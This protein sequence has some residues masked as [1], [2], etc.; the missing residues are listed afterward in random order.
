MF[1]RVARWREYNVRVGPVDPCQ[2]RSIRVTV[3]PE[4]STHLGDCAILALL[5]RSGAGTNLFRS[6]RA[7]RAARIS[8]DV[9]AGLIGDRYC[10]TVAL[11][12]IDGSFIA[13]I[14][15]EDRYILPC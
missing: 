10:W 5:E 2:K 12:C 14:M 8:V 13:R 15:I 6:L 1:S 9:C 4:M 11:V 3:D 7:V